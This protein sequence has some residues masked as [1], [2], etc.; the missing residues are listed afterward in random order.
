MKLVP[1]LLIIKKAFVCPSTSRKQ[2]IGLAFQVVLVLGMSD[3][4]T[5][6]LQL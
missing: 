4:V 6:F 1:S 5:V 3:I 2:V